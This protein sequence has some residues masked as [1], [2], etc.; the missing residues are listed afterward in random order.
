MD[1]AKER[2]Q[3]AKD[4]MKGLEDKV[5]QDGEGYQRVRKSFLLLLGDVSQ[6]T[7]LASQYI[8]GV[9]T[10]RDHKGDNKAHAPMA[11]INVEK[12][13]QALELLKTEVLAE[14]AL[15]LPPE[16]LRML[17][18]DHFYD[19]YD[20]DYYV[21]VRQIVSRIQTTVIDM[22]LDDDTL[23][24]VQEIELQ[25]KEGEKVLQL[26]DLFTALSDAILNEFDGKKA[27]NLKISGNRR[28]LQ[29][30]YIERLIDLKM[31]RTSSS[32]LLSGFPSR[33]PAD[34]KNLAR[35]ELSKVLGNLNKV[36]AK[37]N[38]DSK[39]SDGY[40]RAHIN[41]LVESIK[42]ALEAKVITN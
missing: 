26:P 35:M 1:F 34:A 10:S 5:T 9:Y 12:Q 7:V 21:P 42:L 36:K 3:F 39:I 20:G 27:G 4:N 19:S 18:P 11:P 31:G 37:V 13:M 25:A 29:R 32:Y 41:S 17:A 15:K 40:S 30:A 24:S 33:A 16:L 8:G 2:I 28:D 23:T 22:V 6:S 38:A 14:D